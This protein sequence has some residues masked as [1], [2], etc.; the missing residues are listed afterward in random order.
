MHASCKRITALQIGKQLKSKFL[1]IFLCGA[2][3]AATS[4]GEKDILEVLT[5]EH[6]EALHLLNQPRF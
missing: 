4:T 6:S 3:A 2:G 5:N 1:D